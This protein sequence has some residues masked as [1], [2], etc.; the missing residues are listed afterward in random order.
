M[1]EDA[2]LVALQALIAALEAG[3]LQTREAIDRARHMER[4]VEQGYS[5]R[6][7]LATEERPLLTDLVYRAMAMTNEVVGRLRREEA[8]KLVAEGAKPSEVADIFGLSLEHVHAML[9]AT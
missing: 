5:W 9:D 3:D 1:A 2:A 4:L 7:V 8:R 6:Q